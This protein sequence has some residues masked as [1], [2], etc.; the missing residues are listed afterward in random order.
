MIWIDDV[1][2]DIDY[3]RF[4]HEVNIQRRY[5]LQTAD[6]VNR[7]EVSGV[8]HTYTLTLGG[9]TSELYDEVMEVLCAPVEF[10]TIT[11]PDGKDGYR[12]FEAMFSG[13]SDQLLADNDSDRVWDNLTVVFES[14]SADASG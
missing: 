12:T 3:T 7:S 2:Y 9:M 11:L 5:V 14:R 13:I 10:H 4:D 1:G 8:Y 6:G